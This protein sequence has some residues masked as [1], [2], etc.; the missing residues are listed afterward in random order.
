[1]SSSSPDTART[2]PKLPERI[3]DG[4]DYVTLNITKDHTD[5]QDFPWISKKR[6]GQRVQSPTR[7]RLAQ[8]NE[9]LQ[10]YA[11]RL[12]KKHTFTLPPTHMSK[13]TARTLT[14]SSSSPDTAQTKLNLPERIDED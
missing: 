13:T 5:T 9:P 2:K 6:R 14:M 1:M 11:Q 4:C 12:E 3:D 8:R 10:T 7:Q